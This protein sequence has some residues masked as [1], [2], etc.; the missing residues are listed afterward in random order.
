M[1]FLVYSIDR[2]DHGASRFS[3]Q[4]GIS[5]AGKK[6]PLYR[7]AERMWNQETRQTPLEWELDESD[8]LALLALSA[9]VGET[10]TQ[11]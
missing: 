3:R 1:P 10:L 8:I 4:R 5:L 6:G 9:N 7:H 11:V 2:T